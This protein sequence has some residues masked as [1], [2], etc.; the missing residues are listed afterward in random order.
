MSGLCRVLPSL[1]R[2]IP[3]HS[4]LHPKL[5]PYFPLASRNLNNYTK[6]PSGNNATAVETPEKEELNYDSLLRIQAAA[7]SKDGKALLPA[8]IDCFKF[9]E[10][11]LMRLFLK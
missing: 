4:P 3:V 1:H 2:G 5:A 7:T 8:L 10:F 6:D 11:Q 9:F